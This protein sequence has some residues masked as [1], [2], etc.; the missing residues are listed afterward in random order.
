MILLRDGAAG[1]EVFLLR[2]HRR[3]SFLASAFVFPGGAADP[4]EDDLRLTAAREL[5]EE[6][7]V[8]LA[9]EPVAP[10]VLVRL[11]RALW[12]DGDFA[13]LLADAGVTL[14]LDRL[15]PFAH[16]ITPSVEPKRFSAH[17][18]AARLPPGQTPSFDD[19]ETVDEAWVTP[20]DGLARAD[21]LHLPPPQL[22]TLWELRD[23]AERGVDATLAVA[24]ERAPHIAPFLPRACPLGSGFA[25]LM[26]WDPDYDSRGAGDAAP[27]PPAHPL[28]T[29]PSRFVFEEQQWKHVYAPGS[30]RAD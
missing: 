20:A 22:R 9:S 28:A 8:L 21:D 13:A 4:G 16:W 30:D 17:F 29:G 11:R 7:G 15:R 6:A 25:L 14:D 3:A 27:L 19:R 10:P 24:D 23:A 2:R 5:F 18:F 26:P 1:A 12:E